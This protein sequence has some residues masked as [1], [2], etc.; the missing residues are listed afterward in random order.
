MSKI[1]ML[2]GKICSGKSTY[3]NQLAQKINAVVLSCDELM[4]SLFDEQLGDKHNDILKKCQAYLYNLA[5]QIVHANVNVILDFG[6]WSKV[7]RT[8]LIRL[9]NS[10]NIEVELHYIKIDDNSWLE[11]IKKRNKLVEEGKL[12]CYYVDKNMQR[13]FNENFEEPGIDEN[14]LLIDNSA[15][16]L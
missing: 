10:K 1:I 3:A 14:Y 12:K 4:L 13:I 5:Q 6:F 15:K 11:Q 7:E 9:F 2:C 8:E 16:T